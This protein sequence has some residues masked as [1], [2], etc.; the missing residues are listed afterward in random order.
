MPSSLAKSMVSTKTHCVVITPTTVPTPSRAAAARFSTASPTTVPPNSPI[1]Q[2]TYHQRQE[3]SSASIGNMSALRGPS[4][5]SDGVG[6]LTHGDDGL[7]VRAQFDLPVA[8]L[9]LQVRGHRGDR[10]IAAFHRQVD[11][12]VVGPVPQKAVPGDGHADPCVAGGWVAFEV[13][14]HGVT[15]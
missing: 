13:G 6:Q 7:A 5:V 14:Q 15:A 9:P 4:G 12:G 11:T 2:S 10:V 8:V 3:V 1:R